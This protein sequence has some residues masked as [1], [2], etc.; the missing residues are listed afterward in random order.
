MDKDAT[1]DQFLNHLTQDVPLH[2]LKKV[3][4]S[5]YFDEN[6]NFCGIMSEVVDH[7][8]REHLGGH[9]LFEVW[10]DGNLLYQRPL[11]CKVRAWGASRHKNTII[12]LLDPEDEPNNDNY[13]HMI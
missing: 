2:Q 12:Y 6:M 8:L 4:K 1:S 11:T 9:Y 3:I 10:A 5:C 7:T 13:F